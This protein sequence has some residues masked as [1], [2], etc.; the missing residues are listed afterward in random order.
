VPEAISQEQAIREGF[1]CMEL[2]KHPGWKVIEDEAKTRI[3][4]GLKGLVKIEASK[5]NEV[6]EL[7]HQIKALEWLLSYPVTL[8]RQAQELDK[9]SSEETQQD[10]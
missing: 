10:S 1:D 6:M 9:E 2:L 4:K 3:E 5:V 8:A 7:Q